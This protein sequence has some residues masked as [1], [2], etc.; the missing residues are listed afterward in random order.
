MKYQIVSLG[1]N[2]HEMSSS[3]FQEKKK[4]EKN[5]CL[6]KFLPSMLSTNNDTILLAM[7]RVK[8]RNNLIL[9]I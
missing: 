2:L 5:I 4:S 7:V 1:Y 9:Q 8:W 6:L 3:I